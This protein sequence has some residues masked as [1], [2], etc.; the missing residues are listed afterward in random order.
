MYNRAV[1][2]NGGE[3]PPDGVAI[4]RIPKHSWIIRPRLNQR[5]LS[6]WNYG[7]VLKVGEVVNT[8]H[9][10]IAPDIF[11][12]GSPAASS[13]TEHSRFLGCDQGPRYEPV[14][15]PGFMFGEKFYFPPARTTPP[16]NPPAP[17]LGRVDG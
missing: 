9:S 12:K 2:N 15:L 10:A 6:R 7:P 14:L 5:L 13:I 1:H 4:H 11:G 16:N 17:A 3:L 8:D